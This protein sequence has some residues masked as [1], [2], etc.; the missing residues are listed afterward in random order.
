M[1]NKI[2]SVLFPKYRSH[3]KNHF[4]IFYFILFSFA[5][6]HA[7]QLEFEKAYVSRIGGFSF[8]FNDRYTMGPDVGVLLKGGSFYRSKNVKKILVYSNNNKL[9]YLIELDTAGNI[10]TSGFKTSFYFTTTS[11]RKATDPHI[12]VQSYYKDSILMRTDSL[13]SKEITYRHYDTIMRF[14]HKEQVI[15]KTGSLLN[16]QNDYYNTTY[17]H[18]RIEEKNLFRIRRR[19]VVGIKTKRHVFL[20]RKLPVD[21]E[22]Q[23]L[24]V[25]CKSIEV[26]IFTANKDG[27]DIDTLK[28]AKHPFYRS[29]H[30]KREIKNL[31]SGE[32]FY[33][34]SHYEEPWDC[35]SGRRYKQQESPIYG[36]TSGANGLY[37]TYYREYYPYETDT[38]LINKHAA[39]LKK[40]LEE[41]SRNEIYLDSY[42]DLNLRKKT[43]ERSQIY[44]IRYEYF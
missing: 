36:F 3:M 11:I 9:A 43:P 41:R 8:R 23:R 25:T 21:F 35:G 14:S 32:D 40:N 42:E 29:Y 44:Y 34:P 16:E 28:L 10:I 13:F 18:K 4:F 1:E 6:F 5:Q 38:V 19:N 12:Y 31:V 22:T 17:L 7:Q 27:L 30:P 24:Y 33:E 37:D 2:R 15:Y 39:E 20:S 26:S